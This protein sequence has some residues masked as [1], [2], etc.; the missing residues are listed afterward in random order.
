ME[1]GDSRA[2]L[3][4]LITGLCRNPQLLGGAEPGL[5]ALADP[6]QLERLLRP[7]A[8]LTT[9]G[10]GDPRPTIDAALQAGTLGRMIY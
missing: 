4:Q 2:F 5:N 8:G 6:H 10:V 1:V 9:R 7:E 3:T